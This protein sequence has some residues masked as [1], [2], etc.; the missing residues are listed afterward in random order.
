MTH[1]HTHTQGEQCNNNIPCPVE[2]VRFKKLHIDYCVNYI[3]ASILVVPCQPQSLLLKKKNRY[4]KRHCHDAKSTASYSVIRNEKTSSFSCRSTVNVPLNEL[5]GVYQSFHP[6]I[7]SSSSSK[8]VCLTLT[9]ML[10]LLFRLPLINIWMTST[11]QSKQYS[12][13]KEQLNN[14][15]R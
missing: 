9:H 11:E 8:Q 6:Y 12:L 2:K 3:M 4:L 15:M 5:P 14:S 13:T 10:I 1:T 7:P